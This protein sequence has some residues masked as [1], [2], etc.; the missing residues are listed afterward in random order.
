[1]NMR[2][3]GQRFARNE[4]GM[5]VGSA[6]SRSTVALAILWSITL[7]G[8]SA[9]TS[10]S[11]TQDLSPAEATPSPSSPSSPA[12]LSATTAPADAAPPGAITVNLSSLKF[13]PSA[14][15]ATPGTV[16]FFLKNVGV[17][18]DVYA[19]F[20]HNLAIG[21]D[22]DHLL[23]KSDYVSQGKAVV[24]T[25]QGLQPGTYVVWCSVDM[26]AENGMVGTLTVRP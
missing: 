25:V 12:G 15:T 2:S 17:G 18:D 22:Q 7:A 1:M 3:A 11:P 16:G 24:F 20:K 13:D 4:G 6:V 21:V 19:Q 23:A 10:P 8:C 26:H 14:I 9:A 5:T